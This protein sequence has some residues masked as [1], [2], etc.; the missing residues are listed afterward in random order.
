MS[1][2]NLRKE[3]ESSLPY[4]TGTEKYH[5]CND[6]YLTDGVKYLCD[7]AGAYWLIDVFYSSNLALE[8]VCVTEEFQVLEMTVDL[9]KSN[10]ALTITDGNEAILHTQD[11]EFTDFPL[12]K[13]K[14]YLSDN[15]IMLPSEY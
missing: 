9:E 6:F 3:L 12:E 10:A 11:I 14:L 1:K 8:Q 5:L 4:Y 15:V 13:I 2:E 7:T